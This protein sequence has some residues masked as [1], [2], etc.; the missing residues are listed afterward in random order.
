MLHYC[1]IVMHRYFAPLERQ[2]PDSIDSVPQSHDGEFV[3]ALAPD[4]MHLD[5]TPVDFDIGL[6]VDD[7]Q[8]MRSN[9]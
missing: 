3:A 8:T 9:C 5:S 1:T 6:V 4:Q 2:T 7:L